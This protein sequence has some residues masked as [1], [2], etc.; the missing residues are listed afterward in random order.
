MKVA[1]DC[2]CVSAPDTPTMPRFSD[3]TQNSVTL[4][5]QPGESQVINSTTIQYQK[6][7]AGDY[8]LN[9]S[10]PWSSSSDE[11][12]SRERR[13]ADETKYYVLGSLDAETGYIIRV[14][15]QSFDK[16]VYSPEISFNTRECTLQ[17][18]AMRLIQRLNSNMLTLLKHC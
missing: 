4:S 15:V 9:E 11:D 13:S 7:P 12:D 18:N 6:S 2:C 1:D 14:V 8:W 5:W 17:Y 10:V 3:I 16:V